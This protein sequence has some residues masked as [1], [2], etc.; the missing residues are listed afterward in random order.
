MKHPSILSSP[1]N[2]RSFLKLAAASAALSAFN[3]RIFAQDITLVA[4]TKEGD[5]A[6]GLRICADLVKQKTGVTLEVQSAPEDSFRAKVTADFAAGGGAYDLI[7]M[8]YN[9]MREFQ[10]AGHLLPLDD[11]ISASPDINTADFIPAL[12]N[13]YGRW[14]DQQWALPG[15]AD[16]YIS[17]YRQDLFEDADVQQNFKAR[18]GVDLVVPQTVAEQKVIA[19]FFTKSLNPDSPTE[20]GW[21]NWSE[22][23]GSVWWWG[24]RMSALGG[25]WLTEDNIPNMNNEAGLTALRD[26][27]DM[28]KFAPADV[29]TYEWSKA[30]QSYL[31]GSSAL[32]DEWNSFGTLCNTPEGDFGRSEIVGKSGFTVLSGYDVG[33]E[34]KRASVLGGWCMAVPKYTREPQAAFDVLNVVTSQEAELLREPLGYAPT[35]LS[36]YDKIPEQPTTAHY[37]ATA[38]NFAVATIGADVF[39]PPVGQQ[40]QDYMATVINETI[41]GQHAPEEALA[42]IE[43]EWTRILQDADVYGN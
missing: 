8:P 33:G 7:F 14:G 28:H 34:L 39:A 31:N 2:R 29:A 9:M 24:A 5:V 15:K 38:D 16:V 23:W 18:T 32:F 36:T 12:L 30:N 20:Y 21:T 4:F 11:Y 43:S 41:Q 26:Y 27:L 10:V 25:S 13:A 6:E 22:R 19:E 1:I 35:R 17:C 40:V 42:M 37:Q 3:P